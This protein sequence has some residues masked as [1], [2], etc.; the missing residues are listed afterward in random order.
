MRHCGTTQIHDNENT[1]PASFSKTVI[2]LGLSVDVIDCDSLDF[3][4]LIGSGS[5]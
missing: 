5:G 4:V 1:A 2:F 3:C